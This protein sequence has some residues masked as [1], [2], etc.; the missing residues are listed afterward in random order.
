VD[1]FKDLGFAQSLKNNSH[2]HSLLASGGTADFT[3]T[4]ANATITGGA[5]GVA[6]TYYASLSNAQNKFTPLSSSYTSGSTTLYERVENTTTGCYR[7]VVHL[8]QFVV[9]SISNRMG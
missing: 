8:L 5:S 7:T 3:L 6:V 4:N 9:S 1:Y 2:A